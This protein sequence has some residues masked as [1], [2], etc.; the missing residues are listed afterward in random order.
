M[1][2]GWRYEMVGK[3]LLELLD[4]HLVLYLEKGTIEVTERHQ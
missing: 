2:K 3:E 1:L 4:G